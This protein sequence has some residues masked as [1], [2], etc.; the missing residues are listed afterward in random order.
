[1]VRMEIANA[2]A[3]VSC[4][5]TGRTSLASE[6]IVEIDDDGGGRHRGNVQT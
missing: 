6:I 1:M 2:A 4:G 5:Y 3:L